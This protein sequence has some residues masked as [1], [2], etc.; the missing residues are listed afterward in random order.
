M[1]SG[2]AV[3]EPERGRAPRVTS[4]GSHRRA[5][6][7]RRAPERG[8]PRGRSKPDRHVPAAGAIPPATSPASSGSKPDRHG[9]VAGGCLGRPPRCAG[10]RSTR[11]GGTADRAAG[12]EET[13]A[14]GAHRERSAATIGAGPARGRSS[15]TGLSI[16]AAAWSIRHSFRFLGQRS[17]RGVAPMV[18]AEANLAGRDEGEVNG[19]T[20][21]SHGTTRRR[22][23]HGRWDDTRPSLHGRWTGSVGGR[24]ARNRNAPAALARRSL[25]R[26]KRC[27]RDGP[28]S[29]AFRPGSTAAMGRERENLEAPG[30]GRA[31]DHDDGAS[32]T[33]GRYRHGPPIGSRA[34]SGKRERTPSEGRARAARPTTGQRRPLDRRHDETAAPAFALFSPFSCQ[35]G[36]GGRASGRPPRSRVPES[37]RR[38]RRDREGEVRPSRSGPEV[39]GAAGP[40]VS[41]RSGSTGA[42]SIPCGSSARFVEPGRCAAPSLAASRTPDATRRPTALRLPRAPDRPRPPLCGPADRARPARL[43]DRGRWTAAAPGRALAPRSP[44]GPS[45]PGPLLRPAASLAARGRDTAPPNARRC[46]CRPGS[47]L[48]RE[49][50]IAGGSSSWWRSR[51]DAQLARGPA[52]VGRGAEVRG[53]VRPRARD[54]AP[55]VVGGRVRRLRDGSVP[56]AAARRARR[57]AHGVRRS[58]PCRTGLA[59]ALEDRA[60]CARDTALRGRSGPPG[61]SE[62]VERL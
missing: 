19:S 25:E 7:A 15:A 60:T 61:G 21:R 42:L 1:P 38:M 2:S 20:A 54:G 32:A 8:G 50:A 55:S 3:S 33:G 46:G 58:S 23:R 16:A 28:A 17:G 44:A 49:P 59:P 34:R 36:G 35:T 30:R 53:S 43:R 52:A 22:D 37:T 9:P 62:P 48:A 24:E 51:P 47:R 29:T 5:R 11:P 56:I 45:A 13:Y 6:S 14:L 10:G 39:S 57:G 26:R 4:G 31:A 18:P 40:T 27:R 41:R 12:T